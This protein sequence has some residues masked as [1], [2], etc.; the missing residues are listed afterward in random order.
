MWQS[1]LGII[2]VICAIWIIVDVLTK[3][4]QMDN[5]LK[6]VWIIV[7]IILCV[8]GILVAI[9]YYL[10]VKKKGAKL[11]AKAVVQKAKAVTKKKPAKKKKKK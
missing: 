2:G 1:I 7:S 8:F 11:S 6:A 4:K 3:Q 5:G 10:A 9:V